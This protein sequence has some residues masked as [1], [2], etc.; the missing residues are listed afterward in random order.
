MESSWSSRRKLIYGLSASIVVI[1]IA[2]YSFRDMLFPAPTCSDGKQNGYEIGI[3]CGGTCSLKCASEIIPLSVSWSRAIPTS[4]STYDLVAL[5]SNK[6]V[7]NSTPLLPYIFVVFGA[8]GTPMAQING[9]T[10][11]P[12]DGE[13][14]VIATKVSLPSAPSSVS[15]IVN[16]NVP[17]SAVNERANNPTLRVTTTRYEEGAIPRVYATIVNTKRLRLKNVAVRAVLYDDRGNAYAIGQT[18]IDLLEKEGI[19]DVVFTWNAPLPFAP[20]KIR[21]YPILDPFVVS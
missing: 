19:Q 17:F 2:L 5:I 9:T 18:L 20:T 13:F 14:P 21:V 6:N 7:D 12:V 16:Q 3:D 1:L 4:S 10:P 8:D 15:L 11:V